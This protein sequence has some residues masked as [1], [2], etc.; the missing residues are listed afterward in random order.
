MDAR[1]ARTPG[2][3]AGGRGTG[4]GVSGANPFRPT[5]IMGNRLTRRR[6]A[7]WKESE[8]DDVLKNLK[9]TNF[10][11]FEE[12]ELLLGKQ[13]TLVGGLNGSGKS[14]LIDALAVGLTGTCR[15][16]ETGRG[17][18]ELRRTGSK[19]KWTVSGE[20][21]GDLEGSSFERREGGGPNSQAQADIEA[22]LKVPGRTIRA[23]LYAGELVRITPKE[24]QQLLLDLASSGTVDL[25]KHA[26]LVETAGVTMYGAPIT[27]LWLKEMDLAAIDALYSTAYTARRD[28]GRELRESIPTEPTPPPGAEKVVGKPT[29][30]LQKMI[31][32]MK[33][34]LAKL[35]DQRDKAIDA[36]KVAVIEPSKAKGQLS[37]LE[38]EAEQHQEWLNGVPSKEDQAKL[39]D[40]TLQAV[41]DADTAMRQANQVAS[42]AE[43]E[44]ASYQGL[45]AAI[46]Q[47]MVRVESLTPR[48]DCRACGRKLSKAAIETMANRLSSRG[49]EHETAISEAT[50]RAEKAREVAAAAFAALSEA[51]AKAGQ[52]EGRVEAAESRR[53]ALA[54][55]EAKIAKLEDTTKKAVAGDQADKL[56]D[57]AKTLESRMKVGQERVM[58]LERFIAARLAYEHQAATKKDALARQEALEAVVKASVAG[59]EWREGMGG[60]DTEAFVARVADTLANM[61]SFTV[62]FSPA[63][64]GKDAPIVNGRPAR[65]LSESEL[66]RF[67]VAFAIATA[68]EV[69]LPIVCVDRW[70]ELDVYSANA[71]MGELMLSG[72]Q[73]IV[74]TKLVGTIEEYKAKADKMSNSA[75]AFALV[76]KDGSISAVQ[77]L[78][79]VAAE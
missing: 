73:S 63:L 46:D 72:L 22:I 10:R 3:A 56:E 18:T 30:D 68:K 21:G 70:E 36:F 77:S 26:K 59:G 66:I 9:V 52:L 45:Q 41:K 50:A 4:T 12:A 57:E 58:D 33:A 34:K 39:I 32:D 64:S 7:S 49:R 14:T 62:D 51:Q 75:V 31:V 69:G 40:E 60:K 1:P 8:E 27:K 53:K 38:D 78:T 44:R 5:T 2:R 65:M 17:L 20:F 76:E 79:R 19:S 15:G 55:V 48:D 54:T 61:G 25:S 24:A 23:C 47:D 29:A 42:E 11:C 6:G 67:S 16:A 28:V 74:A 35:A 13:V 37:I 43:S 71:V